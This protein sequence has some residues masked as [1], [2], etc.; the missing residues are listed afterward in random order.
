MRISTAFPLLLAGAALAAPNTERS[1]SIS[2]NHAVSPKHPFHPLPDT[3]HR[4]KVCYVESHGDG[5]DD[6]KYILQAIKKCNNGGRVVFDKSYTIGTALDLQFLKH[7]DLG[8]LFV[9]PDGK[10]EC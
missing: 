5:T 9:S 6:S 3:K 7:I 2:R 1:V 10:L 4:T 8:S